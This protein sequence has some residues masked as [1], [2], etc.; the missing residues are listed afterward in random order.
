[1]FILTLTY[2]APID[3]IDAL[4]P[5]HRDWLAEHYASGQFLASGRQVPRT[6]GVIV[7]HGGSRT[8]I[9]RLVATDPLAEAG[10]CAYGIV[11][12]LAT[13]TTPEL[14]RYRQDPVS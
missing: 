11:E 9:E 8:E 14:A 13:S 7:A 1:M 12:F 6:G 2:T 3:R 5:A 4:L 10:V